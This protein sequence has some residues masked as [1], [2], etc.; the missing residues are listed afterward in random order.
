[1]EPNDNIKQFFKNTFEDFEADV[2]PQAWNNIHNKLSRGGN[3]THSSS[4]NA[5]GLSFGAGKIIVVASVVTVVS[6]AVWFFAKSDDKQAVPSQN[7]QA[8]I[9]QTTLEKNTSISSVENSSNNSS[10]IS[11]NHPSV[12]NSL[13]ESRPLLKN[14]QAQ[15]S[16]ADNKKNTFPENSELLTE[17]NSVSTA[18]QNKS[19]RNT[20]NDKTSL[21]RE[22]QIPK[23][24]TKDNDNENSYA[25]EPSPMVSIYASILSGDA[26]L[27]V[28]F[29]NQGTASSLKWE[30]GDGASS[31]ITSPDHTFIQPGTYEV[32]LSSVNSSGS[33]VNDNVTIQVKSTSEIVKVPNIFTPNGD[34]NNDLFKIDMRNMTFVDMEIFDGKGVIYKWNTMDGSWNGKT[35]NG[36]DAPVGTYYYI[37]NAVGGD[38]VPHSQ[39]GTIELKR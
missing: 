17:N 23:S 15:N 12:S 38:N 3:P 7:N 39:K 6:G 14:P 32:T 29:S 24:G 13:K 25:Q 16:S 33:I 2:N 11:N 31:D 21:V 30:F 26:P 1:M 20:S 5:G 28:T 4:G 35:M 9:S 37:L 10:F 8:K 36:F 27:T 19:G 18:P 22:N 34:G